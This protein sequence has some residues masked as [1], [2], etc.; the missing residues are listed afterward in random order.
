MMRS[1][2][3]LF[4]LWRYS[5]QKISY[6]Y[7]TTMNN[8]I[9]QDKEL[10]AQFDKLG[11][12]A[13]YGTAGFRDLAANMNY[14]TIQSLRLPLE[15]ELSL[16]CTIRPSPTSIWE[17]SFLQVTTS[18]KTMELRSPTSKAT[19]WKRISSHKLRP[20]SIRPT[21]RQQ[22]AILSSFWSKE[23]RLSTINL[24]LFS[25]VEIQG[26][27]LSLCWICWPQE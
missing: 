19:C 8:F 3:N 24:S 2:G 6:C 17:S 7:Y 21:S 25:L 9:E 5:C 20:S 1:F 23:D 10:K 14:V 26:R 16:P 18:V 22:S 11:K 15:L 12:K 13:T 27:Q 4:S